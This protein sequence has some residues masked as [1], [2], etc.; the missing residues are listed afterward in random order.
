LSGAYV[1]LLLGQNDV[2]EATVVNNGYSVQYGG[3]AGANVNYVTK[4]GSNKFHGNANYFWNGRALNAN[5]WFNNHSTPKVPRPF[6]NANQWSASL[7]GPIV[8]DKTF[9]FVD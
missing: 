3:L 1:H 8:Q 9:F 6:D 7:G 2:Q 4:S 5:N